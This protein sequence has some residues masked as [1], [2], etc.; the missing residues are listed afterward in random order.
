MHSFL[1][2]DH[3]L[4]ETIKHKTLI[5]NM[6]GGMKFQS[7]PG[8]LGM[9]SIGEAKLKIGHAMMMILQVGVLEKFKDIPLVTGFDL[10]CFAA[11]VLTSSACFFLL[12]RL[13][14]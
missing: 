8:W 1:E 6:V 3:Y 2:L 9:Q 10:A 11:S 14:H 5:M 13:R 12:S 7:P 4:N